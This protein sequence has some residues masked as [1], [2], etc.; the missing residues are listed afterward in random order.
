M[1][2]NR[3]LFLIYIETRKL[4]IAILECCITIKVTFQPNTLD[5]VLFYCSKYALKSSFLFFHEEAFPDKIFCTYL[6]PL[7]YA[8]EDSVKA[9]PSHFV[10]FWYLIPEF[11]Q[12][13][14][15][16]LFWAFRALCVLYQ[17][18]LEQQSWSLNK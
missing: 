8:L 13:G 4:P 17:V 10:V 15:L 5:A 18:R 2:S 1:E 7:L 12:A 3:H 16:K 9:N 11:W 6:F 14:P